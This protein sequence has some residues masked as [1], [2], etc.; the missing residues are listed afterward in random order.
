MKKLILFILLLLPTFVF[1]QKHE[2][3]LYGKITDDDGKA[4]EL[5]NVAVQN[6]PY[7]VV[8]DSRGGYTLT[9]PADTTL[10]VVFSFVGYEE[11]KLQVKLKPEERRKHDVTMTVSATMLPEMTVHDQSI[12]SST[13]TRLDARETVLLPS[14]AVISSA[15]LHP[16]VAMSIRLQTLPSP[17]A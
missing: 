13:I 6:T 14:A 12:K 5:V 3:V 2:G 16:T 11:V 9:L 1:G 7:G 4:V 15:A 10:N 17:V 8:S